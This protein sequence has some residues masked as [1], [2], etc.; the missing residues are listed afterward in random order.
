L[1]CFAAH[2]DDETIGAG[3]QFTHWHNVRL[4]H[5]TDGA[6]RNMDDARRLGFPSRQAYACARRKE[7]LAALQIAGVSARR[8]YSL[9]FVDQECC[10]NLVDLAGQITDLLLELQPATVL[11]PPYEG[12]HPDHD[13]LAF[14]LHMACR[15]IAQRERDVPLILEH[16][17]YHSRSGS[18]CAGEFLPSDQNPPIVARLSARAEAIKKQMLDCFVTQREVVALFPTSVESFRVAPEYD[19]T[20]PPHAGQLYYEKFN[21]GVTGE[22]W[23]SLAEQAMRH[24][25]LERF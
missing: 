10:R 14:A 7:L 20:T 1:I 4:V 17:L 8:T 25:S 3:G 9:G 11:S 18:F 6:P 13:S 16:T 19:F 5:V 12:G 2:P 21:W 15:I 24:L 22:E 23:R